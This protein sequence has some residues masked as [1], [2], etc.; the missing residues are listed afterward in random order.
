M[1]KI[2]M[3]LVTAVIWICIACLCFVMNKTLAGIVWLAVG[4]VNLIFAVCIMQ[5]NKKAE[6]VSERLE[7]TVNPEGKEKENYPHPLA[8]ETIEL[9]KEVHTISDEYDAGYGYVVN[10]AFKPAKSHAAEV[11]LL[12]VYAPEEDYGQEGAVP[13]IAVQT[14][15]EVYCAVEEYQERKTFEGA[16]S[17]EPLEGR[18]LFRAKRDYYG[19]RMYFYGFEPG[20]E[21]YWDKGGLCLVYPKKYIGTEEEE[22]LMRVLDEAAGSLNIPSF[23]G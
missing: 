10:K 15:D 2:N 22:K 12:S 11:E 17:I 6:A 14:D 21:A 5:L 9:S 4:V 7:K 13:Y 20:G 3:S 19:D 16:V 18:F 1:K 8:A 23:G